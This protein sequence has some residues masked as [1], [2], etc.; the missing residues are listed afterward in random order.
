MNGTTHLFLP[1]N[2]LCWSVLKAKLSLFQGCDAAKKV[3][4]VASGVSSQCQY[5]VFEPNQKVEFK[6]TPQSSPR[7][8]ALP[9][10]PPSFKGK[11]KAGAVVEFEGEEGVG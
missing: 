2:L 8:I 6:M 10:S 7:V 4:L 3:V 1:G 5:I 9:L 11:G